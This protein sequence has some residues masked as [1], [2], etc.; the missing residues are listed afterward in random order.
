MA[1]DPAQQ[2]D[3]NMADIP[4]P[5]HPPPLLAPAQRAQLCEHGFLDPWTVPAALAQ[6]ID[7]LLA[8][9]AAFFALPP[10]TKALLFPSAPG[11][12]EQGY[13][14]LP[15]EKEFLTLRHHHHHHQPSPPAAALPPEA[16][17]LAAA[18]TAATAQVW[19]RAAPLLHRMLADAGQH[20]GTVA[21]GAWAAVAPSTTLTLPGSGAAATPTLARLFRYAPGGGGGAAPHRDLG[22]LTLCVS[23]AP[24]L[25]VQDGAAGAWR[26]AT[27][28]ATVLAGRTLRVLSANR[29]PAALHRVRA[30]GPGRDS[31]VLALRPAAAA[32]VDL[33]GFGGEGWVSGPALWDRIRRQQVNVNAPR[34]VRERQ[35]EEREGRRSCRARGRTV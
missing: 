2:I 17:H 32:V 34:E 18:L 5:P 16:A 1:S 25:Q 24:G 35:W 6:D 22:L 26:D 28:P 10:A 29:V 15:G 19:A 21:P 3:I 7:A 11:D 4:P 14:L 20:L 33:A 9:A 23:R 31:F 8:A 12:T 27:G 30:A 13:N